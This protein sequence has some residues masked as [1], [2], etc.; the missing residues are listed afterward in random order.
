MNNEKNKQNKNQH[1]TFVWQE[2][3]NYK[4]SNQNSINS[5]TTT[6]TT[7]INIENRIFVRLNS[8]YPVWRNR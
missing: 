6:T 1:D 2:I 4:L 8:I 3:I 7:S 5:I